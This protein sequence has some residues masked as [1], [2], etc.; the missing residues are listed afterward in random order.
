MEAPDR[1][2]SVH[3]T[4]LPKRMPT[5]RTRIN[6]RSS[7][8]FNLSRDLHTRSSQIWPSKVPVHPLEAVALP[9][10][11]WRPLSLVAETQ[12]PRKT[13]CLI[14]LGAR[15]LPD[16]LYLSST[17]NPHSC[18]ALTRGLA[19]SENCNGQAVLNFSQVT[20]VRYPHSALPAW[21]RPGVSALEAK[22]GWLATSSAPFRIRPW[23]PLFDPWIDKT[24]QDASELPSREG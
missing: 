22:A 5:G 24:V 8:D 13:G 19:E 21:H 9:H 6:Y 11:C 10:R 1:E 12:I 20:W 16:D 3:R 4:Q 14:Q 23:L 18:N 2:I 15:D 7:S 17:F